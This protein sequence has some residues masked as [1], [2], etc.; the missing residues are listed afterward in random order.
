MSLTKG[1]GYSGRDAKGRCHVVQ[2]DHG[3]DAELVSRAPDHF[4]DILACDGVEPAPAL[5]VICDLE[6]A[7]GANK[8]TKESRGLP[9]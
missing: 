4:V 5:Q 6:P 7:I 9:C 2:D 1:H 8:A 3:G